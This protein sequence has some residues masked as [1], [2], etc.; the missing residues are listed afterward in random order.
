M[1]T[2]DEANEDTINTFEETVAAV[3]LSVDSVSLFFSYLQTLNCA[4]WL[5]T[6]FHEIEAPLC[7]MSYALSQAR[8]PQGV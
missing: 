8:Y 4:N 3:D 1:L 7:S 6:N 5:E 2:V